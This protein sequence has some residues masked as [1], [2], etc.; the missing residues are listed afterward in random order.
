MKVGKIKIVNGGTIIRI[1][2]MGIRIGG[3]VES[4]QKV[5]IGEHQSVTF[6]ENPEV[7]EGTR[8][9][10]EAIRRPTNCLGESVCV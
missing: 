4:V 8:R 3:S 1:G 7:A 6:D 9:L 10:A 2:M 5:Q